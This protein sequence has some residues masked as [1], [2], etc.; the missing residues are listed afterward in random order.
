[1]TSSHVDKK[2]S[3]SASRGPIYR[4]GAASVGGCGRLPTSGTGSPSGMLAGGG[5]GILACQ[6]HLQNS[7]QTGWHSA[8]NST[9]RAKAFGIA[10]AIARSVPAN[11]GGCGRLGAMGIYQ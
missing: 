7:I 8:C 1:M 10:L 3:K 9:I 4:K 5:A 11:F 2:Q 6:L